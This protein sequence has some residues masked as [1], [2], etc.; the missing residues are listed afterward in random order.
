MIR[1]CWVFVQTLIV[2]LVFLVTCIQSEAVA[3]TSPGEEAFE[4]HCF[5]CHP[6]GGN[7]ITPGKTLRSADLQKSGILT[8]ADIVSK[9]RTPGPLMR[10]FDEAIIPE[11]TA[12]AIAEYILRA[13]R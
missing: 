2:G 5:V 8:A 7:V 13:F 10:R 9:I 6:K 11:E 3:K 1:I 12:Q 4:R